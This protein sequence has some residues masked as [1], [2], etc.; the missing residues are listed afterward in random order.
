[1]RV[2]DL[3][4]TIVLLVG[5]VPSAAVASYMGVFVAFASDSCGASCNMG[6]LEFAFGFGIVAPWVLLVAALVVGI[7]LLVRRR[8]AFWV[9]LVA[10]ALMVVAFFVA[11]AL[12]AAAVGW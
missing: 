3:V 1:M 9:P 12:A 6:L 2:W 10:A 4:L 7:V 8:I 5:L 11:F